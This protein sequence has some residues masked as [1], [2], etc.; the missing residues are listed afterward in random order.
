MFPSSS[1]PISNGK[2]GLRRRQS[3]AAGVDAQENLLSHPMVRIPE[4]IGPSS[5]TSRRRTGWMSA[6]SDG[7]VAPGAGQ[8]RGQARYPGVEMSV[9]L[10]RRRSRMTRTR[11]IMTTF[12]VFCARTTGKPIPIAQDH[13]VNTGL[14]PTCRSSGRPGQELLGLRGHRPACLLSLDRLDGRGGQVYL[15]G[16]RWGGLVR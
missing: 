5:L 4:R 15:I 7:A 3:E 6:C 11:G 9:E 16:S 14:T 12:S 2:P 8:V 10:L 1:V 13:E